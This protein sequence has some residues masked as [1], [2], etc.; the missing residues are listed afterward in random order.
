MI[1]RRAAPALVVATLTVALFA[2]RGIGIGLGD[3]VV[4]A[5]VAHAVGAGD[6][7][8][9]Y[10]IKLRGDGFD[11]NGSSGRVSEGNVRGRAVLRVSRVAG[12]ADPRNLRVEIVL[13]KVLV[14]SLID[15]ATPT[16]A[17][18]G[19][20]IL[21]GDSLTVIGAGQSNFVNALTLRFLKR[22][23]RVAG[24]WIAS[25]PGSAATDGFV[26]G[27]GLAFRGKRLRKPGSI[28]VVAASR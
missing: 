17:L 10:V 6:A 1:A 15:R 26:S 7:I 12:S 19:R 28:D 23:R 24:W 27:M 20:G 2:A 16:P 18:A 8:G 14:G 21:V 13:E 11:R 25:F 5:P 22:G 3:G 9:E 4:P